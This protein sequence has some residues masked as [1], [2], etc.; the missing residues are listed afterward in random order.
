MSSG[1]A[2]RDFLVVETTKAK[3]PMTPCVVFYIPECW[4][5]G[6]KIPYDV[7]CEEIRNHPEEDGFLKAVILEHKP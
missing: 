6:M 4:Y 5:V 3:A 2:R 7:C 1:S